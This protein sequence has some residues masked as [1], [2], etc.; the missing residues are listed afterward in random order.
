[1]IK[2]PK[3]DLS[4]RL[5][6]GVVKFTLFTSEKIIMKPLSQTS[7]GI[8]RAQEKINRAMPESETAP[9]GKKTAKIKEGLAKKSDEFALRSDTQ[10]APLSHSAPVTTTQRKNS[11]QSIPANLVK[12]MLSGKDGPFNR[13]QLLAFSSSP[14]TDKDVRQIP[15][16][17]PAQLLS[18][19]DVWTWG[20]KLRKSCQK[21]FDKQGQQAYANAV[22]TA[23]FPDDVKKSAHLP[24]KLE[25]FCLALDAQVIQQ[26]RG[27]GLTDDEFDTLRMR[28]LGGFINGRVLYKHLRPEIMEEEASQKETQMDV[29]LLNA[30]ADKLS[31]Y[32]DKIMT[33]NDALRQPVPVALPPV[34]EKLSPK[35]QVRKLLGRESIME[36]ENSKYAEE[37]YQRAAIFLGSS[38][39]NKRF[40]MTSLLS[41]YLQIPADANN[42]YL[43]KL[44]RA[45]EFIY[46]NRHAFDKLNEEG[47]F[48][49][50]NQIELISSPDRRKTLSTASLLEALKFASA[51]L[52]PVQEGDSESESTSD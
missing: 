16:T 12:D 28:V 45:V 21:I 40:L 36:I 38:V 3:G 9:Q 14:I 47:Q 20:D 26:C 7:N 10:H 37:F 5:K 39:R 49:L 32:L 8:N 4:N 17:W 52:S 6:V 41:L 33:V 27:S 24:D 35:M 51:I 11:S 23:I 46:D 43:S 50:L 15:R 13:Q 34:Q 18:A 29:D 30:A 2:E 48:Y 19:K 25:D 44:D 1:M 42:N 22:I 31:F